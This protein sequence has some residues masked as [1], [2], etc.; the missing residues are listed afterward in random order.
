MSNR[1]GHARR[2]SGCPDAAGAAGGA[3]GGATAV[4]PV[5]VVRTER[6]WSVVAPQ[7][8]ADV[9]DLLEGLSLADLLAEAAGVVPE[10]DRTARRA[11]RGPA[12]SAPAPEADPR[13]ARLAAVERTVAQLEHALAAR[14]ATERAIGVLAERHHTTPR[15]AF[16]LLRGEARSSGR[17]VH[18]LA[19]EV[20][21]GLDERP[22]VPPAAGPSDPPAEATARPPA[23]RAGGGRRTRTR[24]G[25]VVAGDGRS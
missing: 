24:S 10:L 6:G 13:D 8:S 19:R 22:A 5:M 1:L 25:A 7:G 16:E 23:P 12:A 2:A 18:E 4:S 14:V 21:A 9:G 17:P 20:L 15:S 3:T 11:A